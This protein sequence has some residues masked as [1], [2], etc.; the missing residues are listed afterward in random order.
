MSPIC[1]FPVSILLPLTA[2]VA[3]LAR[4]VRVRDLLQ[5]VV[6]VVTEG[7]DLPPRIGD[8]LQPARF[9]TVAHAAP[10]TRRCEP[11]ARAAAVLSS[12]VLEG[13]IE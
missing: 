2:A 7:L 6:E 11:A 13:S 1:L 4:G 3:I 10:S 8:G 12:L 9:G 5:R